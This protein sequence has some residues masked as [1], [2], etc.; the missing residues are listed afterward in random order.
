MAIKKLMKRESRNDI[1]LENILDCWYKIIA[2]T[3]WSNMEFLNVKKVLTIYVLV[4][5]Y[6]YWIGCNSKIL[7]YITLRWTQ[8]RNIIS[9]NY[10]KNTKLLSG[11]NRTIDFYKKY[12]MIKK[13]L[14]RRS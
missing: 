1:F 4:L 6:W 13:H 14:K 8:R 5:R 7:K 10:V 2:T 3:F 12:V 11:R 9:E